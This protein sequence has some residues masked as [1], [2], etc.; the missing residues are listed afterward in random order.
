M[1]RLAD[2]V[3]EERRLQI[4]SLLAESNAYTAS[5]DVLHLVLGQMGLGVSHDRLATDLEWLTEQELV[6]L[7]RIG[8]VATAEVSVRGLDVARGLARVPGVARPKPGV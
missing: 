2:L 6:N 4:L 3:T 5:V 1:S 8:A 7:N